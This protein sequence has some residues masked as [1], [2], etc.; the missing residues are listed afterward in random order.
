MNE[1]GTLLYFGETL[2]CVLFVTFFLLRSHGWWRSR[3]GPN[4]L[5]MMFV[6]AVLQSLG[7]ISRLPVLRDWFMAHADAVRFWSFLALFVVVWWRF[8]LLL[9]I[10]HED[11]VLAR[12]DA[13]GAHE[14][15]IEARGDAAGAHEDALEARQDAEEIR[16]IRRSTGDTDPDL[17]PVAS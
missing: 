14:D 4:L 5:A 3:M 11:A 12:S 2:G 13:E 1:A 8:F 16:Q 9:K 6:L 10:Q 7:V 15:A 17:K